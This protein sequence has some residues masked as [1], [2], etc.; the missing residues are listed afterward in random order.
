M[1]GVRKAFAESEKTQREL[2]GLLQA[3]WRVKWHSEKLLHDSDRLLSD[4]VSG[5]RAGVSRK[6]IWGDGEEWEG[7]GMPFA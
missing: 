5:R 1:E 6:G 3:F 7:V 2:E 4:C